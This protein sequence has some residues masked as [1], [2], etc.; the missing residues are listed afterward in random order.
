VRVPSF[1]LKPRWPV[2]IDR[3]DDEPGVASAPGLPG[4]GEEDKGADPVVTVP[5]R[6]GPTGEPEGEIRCRKSAADGWDARIWR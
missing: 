2:T 5:T 6:F 4:P 1:P 3:E